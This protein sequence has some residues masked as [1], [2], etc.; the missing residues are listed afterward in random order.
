MLVPV[1][2]KDVEQALKTLKRKLQKEGYF[3]AIRQRAFYETPSRKKRRKQTEA[4][5]RRVK[6]C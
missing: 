6:G 1:H 5:R 4:A 3:R 2:N